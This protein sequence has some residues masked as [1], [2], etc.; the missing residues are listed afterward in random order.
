MRINDH[1]AEG[2]IHCGRIVYS[3]MYDL[4][5]GSALIVWLDR[6]GNDRNGRTRHSEP[7]RLKSTAVRHAIFAISLSSI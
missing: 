5:G 1:S 4:E 6:A 3:V 7:Q 2:F